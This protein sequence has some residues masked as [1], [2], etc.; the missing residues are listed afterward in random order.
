MMP[1][2]CGVGL[3][4]ATGSAIGSGLTFTQL[5]IERRTDDPAITSLPHVASPLTGTKKSNARSSPRNS[6]LRSSQVSTASKAQQARWPSPPH[7]VASDTGMQVSAPT[8]QAFGNCPSGTGRSPAAQAPAFPS[9]AQQARWPG[10]P[11]AP[12]SRASAL[13]GANRHT[14]TANSPAIKGR[15]HK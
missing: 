15:V 9:K 12:C 5:P 3:Q 8:R 7:A 6:R 2:G 13:A 14:K 4:P 1:R 11:Q 10:P